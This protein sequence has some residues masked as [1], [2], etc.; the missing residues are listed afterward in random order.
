MYFARLN[1]MFLPVK[2]LAC[3]SS[4]PR[5]LIWCFDSRLH[6]DSR[7]DVIYQHYFSDSVILN[8]LLNHYPP[9]LLDQLLF[10]QAS[11]AWLVKSVFI[12]TE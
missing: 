8:V 11:Y 12:L 2:H 7:F 4:T 9:V 5:L 3:Y 6:F 1:L 10:E